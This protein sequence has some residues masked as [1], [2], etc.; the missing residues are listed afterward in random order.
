MI[1]SWDS[2]STWTRNVGSSFWN[3]LSAREKFGDSFPSGRIEREM[4]G[5]GTYIEVY[6]SARPESARVTYH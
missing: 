3:R 1:V 4:T 5:S 2:E 6:L